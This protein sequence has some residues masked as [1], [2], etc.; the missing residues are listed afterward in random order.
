MYKM[1]TVVFNIVIKKCGERVNLVGTI[2]FLCI[3]L[4]F[5][6]HVANKQYSDNFNNGGGLLSSAYAFECTVL[7][8]YNC[9]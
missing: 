3:L 1:C 2:S 6:L 9:Y 7:Q 8:N 5:V 4:K